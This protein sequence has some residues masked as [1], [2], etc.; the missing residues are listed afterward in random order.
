MLSELNAGRGPFYEVPVGFGVMLVAVVLPCID[1]VGEDLLVGDAAIQDVRR[2]HAS[3]SAVSATACSRHVMPFE[4][5][6]EPSG[7][8]GGQL[9]R[10]IRLYGDLG[11]VHQHDLAAS[12]NACR[13]RSL[14]TSA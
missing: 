2:E 1:F 14:S 12:E 9:R 5:L 8:G 3:D 7:L 11:Y 4:A 13:T 6:S 10:A